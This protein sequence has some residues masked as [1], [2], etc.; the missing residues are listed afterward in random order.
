MLLTMG[1]LTLADPA[2]KATYTFT[3]V[4]DVHNAI[5]NYGYI[6]IRSDNSQFLVQ[7]FEGG[8]LL[9]GAPINIY[10]NGHWGEGQKELLEPYWQNGSIPRPSADILNLPVEPLSPETQANYEAYQAAQTPFGLGIPTQYLLIGG[11]LL[12]VLFMSRRR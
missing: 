6:P 4:P 10:I 12:A 3:T 1:R 8:Y 2:S 5:K 9:D 11:G 7:E